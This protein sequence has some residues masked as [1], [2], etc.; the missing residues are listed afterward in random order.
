MKLLKYAIGLI[1]GLYLMAQPNTSFG[2]SKELSVI[3]VK[4]PKDEKEVYLGAFL[5]PLDR[6]LRKALNV[7]SKSG[8][9]IVDVMA[10]SPAEV[11]GLQEDDIIVKAEGKDIR[12]VEDIKQILAKKKIGDEIK[13]NIIRD[14]STKSISVKL[15]R[16][17]ARKSEVMIWDAFGRPL[18][19]CLGVDV[20]DLDQDLASYFQVASDGGVLVIGVRSNSPA[21]KSGIKSG[22][23]ITRVHEED[24]A[25]VADLKD[26]I[27]DIEASDSI[28]ISLIRKGV[29]K[30][31]TAELEEKCWDKK[32]F[33]ITPDLFHKNLP[34]VKIYPDELKFKMPKPLISSDFEDLAEMKK[35]MKK[36]K[37]EIEEL[38][39]ELK[40]Q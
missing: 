36:L 35:E 13:L 33:H 12:K 1:I 18:N 6:T 16:A 29:A 34:R 9:V 2:A 25:S 15:D 19:Q 22:D 39:K 7:K 28:K 38:K 3:A 24:I 10:D 11:A 21:E 20:A 17:R 40:K 30:T 32:V 8:V 31:I 14:N 37:K 5:Q 27:T 23:I 4:S 26:V